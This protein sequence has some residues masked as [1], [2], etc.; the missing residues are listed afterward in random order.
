M[1]RINYTQYRRDIE[2]TGKTFFDVTDLRKF[3]HSTPKSLKVL[4]SNW[5][6][7]NLIRHL[8]RNVYTFDT[9][10]VNFLKLANERVPNSYIS[11]EYALFYYG[12][13]DQVPTTV[14]LAT[15]E[16]SRVLDMSNWVFEYSHLK[17]NL[18]FGYILKDGFFIATPEK[19]FA[20]LLYLISVGKRLSDLGSLNISFFNIAV[21]KKILKRYPDFVLNRAKELLKFT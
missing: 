15:I 14:T 1:L 17:S 19:S 2:R 9:S 8:G 16:K 12:L 13:I 11:F 4:L 20:D 5:T 6:K 7:K 18:F 10:R 21:L 3:Y